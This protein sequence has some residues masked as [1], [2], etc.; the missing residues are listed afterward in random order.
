MKPVRMSAVVAALLLLLSLPALAETMY[1]RTSTAVRSGKGLSAE[2]IGTLKQGDAVT[3][4]A[5]EGSYYRLAFGGRTGYVYFN[6]L[7]QEKP[8][9]VAALLGS[10]PGGGGIE[11]TELEAGGALRGLSPMAEQYARQSQV[12][13]WAVQAV[14]AMG[15]RKIS[16]EELEAFQ[17][18]GGLGEYREGGV[19]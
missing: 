1:A 19:E 2:T 17:R 6:K 13:P 16:A 10:G 15:A 14:E 8:E 11:L 12:P 4:V 3:V 7:S 9:D 18:E 5:R